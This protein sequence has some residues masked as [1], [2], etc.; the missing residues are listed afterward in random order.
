M[1]LHAAQAGAQVRE[2][3]YDHGPGFAFDWLTGWTSLHARAAWSVEVVTPGEYAVELL[4]NVREE[5]AGARIRVSAA[6]SSGKPSRGPSPA[7]GL[8][9]PTGTAEKTPACTW[10]LGSPVRRHIET[11]G[12]IYH[13]CGR[14]IGHSRPGSHDPQRRH[15]EIR[16][17]PLTA[18]RG[19]LCWSGHRLPRPRS[20]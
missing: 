10:H 7:R 12:R 20:V 14:G 8:S 18:G 9:R 15:I 2:L 6:G 1:T 11:P 4:C 19:G 3:K 16:E 17:G 5:D 13:T